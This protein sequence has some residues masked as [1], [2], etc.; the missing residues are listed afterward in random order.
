MA[1]TTRRECAPPTFQMFTFYIAKTASN[2]GLASTRAIYE[3]AIEVLPD[4]QTAEMCLRFASL[5]RK[6]GEIDR[7]RA[8]YKYAS[9]FCDPRV[10]RP[11]GTQHQAISKNFGA[12]F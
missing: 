8:I 5:E 6:L 3:A 9:Q 4:R 11:S 7:A 2:F 10:S 1:L 12:D